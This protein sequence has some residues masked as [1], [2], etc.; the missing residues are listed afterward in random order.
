MASQTIVAEVSKSTQFQQ[1]VADVP[2]GNPESRLFEAVKR[3]YKSDHQAEYL[4]I[5]AE[6]ELLLQQ[7]QADIQKMS[8]IANP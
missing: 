2:P 1:S 3:L 5:N 7:L 6:A 4:D 8:A